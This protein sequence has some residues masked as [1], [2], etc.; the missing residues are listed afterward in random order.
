MTELKI[1]EYRGFAVVGLGKM[2]IM[3]SSML[4]VVKGGKVAALVDRDAKLTENVRSM[5]IKAP[6]FTDLETCLSE[7]RPEGVWIATPQFTHRAL[8]ETCLQQNVP[9]F[10][11]KPLSNSLEDARA[12]VRLARSRPDVPVAIGYMLAHNPL[13]SRASEFLAGGVLGDLKSFRASC[14]LSQVFQPMKGWTFTKD[15]AGGGVLINSGCHLL[16][17]LIQLFG[18]PKGVFV[19][20][21]G[22]HNPVEDTLTAIFDFE[23]GLSGSL[24]VTWSVPGHESQTHDVEVVGTAGTLNVGNQWL[25]LWLSHKADQLPAGWSQWHREE[26]PPLASFNLSPD[27]CGHEFFL[28]DQDFVEAVRKGRKPRVGVE[29]ALVVQ[30]LVEALYQGMESGQYTEL[31]REDAP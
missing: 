29:E 9:V 20:G 22:V 13:F 17:V 27:Y 30:E 16:Y 7:V 3:H 4:G 23:S 15:K 21:S 31:P 10:C 6:T 26:T 8:V 19:R 14:R 11:E 5:G 2:G 12:M 24:E 28:E 25:R 1:K 18:R